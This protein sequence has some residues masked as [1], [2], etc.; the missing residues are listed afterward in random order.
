[1]CVNQITS[2][3]FW[4][5]VKMGIPKSVTLHIWPRRAG[6]PLKIR[7]AL[8]ILRDGIEKDRPLAGSGGEPTI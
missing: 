7:T 1:M 4:L 3:H 8:L 6:P 2:N 5:M